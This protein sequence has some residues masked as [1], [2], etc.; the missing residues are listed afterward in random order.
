MVPVQCLLYYLVFMD[1]FMQFTKNPEFVIKYTYLTVKAQELTSLPYYCIPAGYRPSNFGKPLGWQVFPITTPLQVIESKP[2]FYH[3]NTYRYVYILNCQIIVNSGACQASLL[4]CPYRLF[5]LCHFFYYA[6]NLY[7][8]SVN[9]SLQYAN[10]VTAILP[11]CQ[12]ST[13][14]FYSMIKINM[15]FRRLLKDR[16]TPINQFNRA[17]H[18]L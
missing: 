6:K 16:S 2:I 8:N 1:F 5:T 15:P 7:G 12:F 11:L 18:R 10:S 17:A 9:A 13:M 3:A 14:P 4:L